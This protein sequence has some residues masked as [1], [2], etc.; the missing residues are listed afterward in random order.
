MLE[1]E[2]SVGVTISATSICDT[3]A[4]Y[5]AKVLQ[6]RLVSHPGYRYTARFADKKQS[7]SDSP[8]IRDKSGWITSNYKA[9]KLSSYDASIPSQAVAQL[10]IVKQ[11][12]AQSKIASKYDV[13]W[14]Y[15][16]LCSIQGAQ[17][18]S[19]RTFTGDS[20]RNFFSQTILWVIKNI[21]VETPAP[22]TPTMVSLFLSNSK[23]ASQM[24][25]Q[26]LKNG[27]H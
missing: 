12:N 14:A 8:K 2:P 7:L 26:C 20:T 13:V 17:N 19:L 1:E 4:Y 9:R 3:I 23:P 18:I 6:S 21:T 10:L 16:L 27:F 5:T 15:I 25:H 11:N 24:I 22:N